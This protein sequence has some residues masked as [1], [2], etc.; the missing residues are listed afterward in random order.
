M[1]ATTDRRPQQPFSLP[2]PNDLLKLAYQ[3]FQQGK[4]A[5][6]LAHKQ[7]NTRVL[8]AIKPLP[9]RNQSLPPEVFQL[10][11]RR[12]QTLLETDWQD[13][14]RGVYGPEL[15]FENAWDEFLKFY[16]LVIWDGFQTWMRL[17]EKRFQEFSPSIDTNG[18][19]K[20]YLQNFHYQTDGYL[21]DWSANLYDLQVELL[22]NGTADAMRRRVLAPIAQGARAFPEVTGR[23]LRVL[24]V[25]CGTGRTLRFIRSILPKAALFGLDLSPAYLRKANQM[26]SQQPGELPQLAQGQGEALPY[27]DDYFHVTTSTFLF[28]ELPG[29]VRSQVI[30][31]LFRVTKPG[32]TVVLCDSIQAADAPELEPVLAGFPAA[33]HEPFYRHYITDDLVAYLDKAGFEQVETSTHFLSKYWVARKPSDRPENPEN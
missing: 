13:V 9:Q 20:Y 5:F 21:S 19:P 10:L 22:F 27:V 18:Y 17:S 3:T 8:N 1:T 26:L 28:H 15:V 29:P 4:G 32:G 23:D 24:D 30:Q 14:E 12:M 7:M 25:A 31:E 2:N 33:F 16:P 6:S 11:Q